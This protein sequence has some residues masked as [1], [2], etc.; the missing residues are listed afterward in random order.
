MGVPVESLV[1]YGAVAQ[2]LEGSGRESGTAVRYQD[3]RQIRSRH[4]DLVAQY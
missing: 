2:V 1:T 3:I 4:Y